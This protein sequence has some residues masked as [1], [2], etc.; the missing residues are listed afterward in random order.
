MVNVNIRNNVT[1]VGRTTRAPKIIKNSDD[2]HKV[3]FTLAVSDNYK[4][5]GK[6]LAQYVPVQAFLPKDSPMLAMYESIEKG[7]L[8]GVSAQLRSVNYEKDGERVYEIQIQI[9]T[10][11]FGLES[12]AARDARALATGEVE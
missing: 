4:T 11:D 6:V 8:L 7:Q 1:L 12:Q 3:M 10:I 2:S 9:Q 5:K